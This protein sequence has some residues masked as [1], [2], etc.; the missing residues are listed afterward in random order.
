MALQNPWPVDGAKYTGN[1]ISTWVGTRTRGVVSVDDCLRVVAGTGTRRANILEGVAFFKGATPQYGQYGGQSVYNSAD[2]VSYVEF[3]AN[4]AGMNSLDVVILRLNM[5]TTPWKCE[6]VTRKGTPT[7]ASNPSI[8]GTPIRNGSYY[9]LWL[10]A[11]PISGTTMGA[12]RDLRLD[13]NYCGIMRDGIT[14]IPTAGLTAEWNAWF[15]TVK[16]VTQPAVD[17]ITNMIAAAG[18]ANAAAQS[19]NTAADSANNAA[20]TIQGFLLY[21]NVEYYVDFTSGD[22]ATGNG[23]QSSP[24]GTIRRTLLALPKNLNGKFASIYVSG[25]DSSYSENVSVDN[26]FGGLVR[27]VFG[28]VGEFTSGI[29]FSITNSL[30]G[31]FQDDTDDAPIMLRSLQQY[32]NSV[33]IT[34]KVSFKHN[35]GV[36]FPVEVNNSRLNALEMSVDGYVGGVRSSDNSSVFINRFYFANNSQ[37]DLN[38]RRGATLTYVTATPLFAEVLKEVTSDGG[39]IYTG[40]QGSGGEY[41][42]ATKQT[43]TKYDVPVEVNFGSENGITAAVVRSNGV[44]QI[45]DGTD[46]QSG[47]TN[48]RDIRASDIGGDSGLQED[49]ILYVD[50]TRGSDVSGDGTQGN[51][52]GTPYWAVDSIPKNL[53]GHDATVYISAYDQDAPVIESEIDVRGFFGGWVHLNFGQM[54]LSSGQAFSLYVHDAKCVVSMSED[55]KDGEGNSY[56]GIEYILSG[57]G[58][59]VV[60]DTDIYYKTVSVSLYSPCGEARGNGKFRNL[61]TAYID[62][63]FPGIQCEETGDVFVY[64]LLGI[65]TYYGLLAG[66]GSGGGKAT[67][68]FSANASPYAQQNGVLIGDG[69][70]IVGQD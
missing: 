62:G 6:F 52:Y 36:A 59:D 31:I 27:I 11:A 13:E 38:A 53:N 42:P 20:A 33:V 65:N 45:A 14:Q 9:E 19:A 34:D 7:T 32:N 37:F 51:P 63:S 60:V 35:S 68:M 4:A 22:D 58:G 17:D 16:N 21:S 48:Y 57:E 67:Y 28:N 66:A 47:E 24:W 8:T 44:P 29:G 23:T 30:V 2:P 55:S 18:N 46:P 12:I 64:R 40:A 41:L 39:R 49:V 15:N 70:I 3:T 43:P 69:Q 26:F 56:G 54:E 25:G 5:T 50:L 61:G 10:A 1:A